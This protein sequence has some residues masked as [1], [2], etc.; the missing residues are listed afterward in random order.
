[1]RTNAYEN[2]RMRMNTYECVRT[3]VYKDS[4][5][6]DY[7]DY[8]SGRD[9]YNLGHRLDRRVRGHSPPARFFLPAFLAGGGPLVYRPLTCRLSFCSTG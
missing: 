7:A 1:M 6:P 4:G 9:P 3:Q 5:H 2:A 8:G